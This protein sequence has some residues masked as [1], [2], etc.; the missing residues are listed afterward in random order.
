MTAGYLRRSLRRS[1]P[2]PLLA[3]LA[4]SISSS[5]PAT[6]YHPS[7]SHLVTRN[8][9]I[10]KRSLNNQ[11]RPY[12]SS[13]AT[14]QQR[15]FED[16]AETLS[17]QP[18]QP[19]PS[20]LPGKLS[21]RQTPRF[22]NLMGKYKDA[23][24]PRPKE[25]TDSLLDSLL[26]KALNPSSYSNSRSDNK[27]GAIGLD[28]ESVPNS[29]SVVEAARA[30]ARRNNLQAPTQGRFASG[31]LIPRPDGSL[32]T[33]QSISDIQEREPTRAVA[34]IKSRPSLGRTVEVMPNRGFD[35]GRAF[36]TLEIACSINNVRSDAI[37]QRFHE[38]PGLKRK[39]LKSQRWRRRFKT[40]FKGMVEKVKS[41]RRKGW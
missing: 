21:S 7:R 8:N 28:G 32:A 12:A 36:R 27:K 2:S 11:S 33:L 25:E 15:S 14:A 9:S 34:T 23:Q 29:A 39:R 10:C 4:P 6:A 19:A 30:E 16:E 1:Q 40:G 22:S 24:P 35:L 41:M 37:K 20:R 17:S 26:D 3:L 18:A 13:S 5:S 38:R 31:M